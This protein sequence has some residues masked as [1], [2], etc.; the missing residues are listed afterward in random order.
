MSLFTLALKQF[1]RYQ[2]NNSNFSQ[3]FSEIIYYYTNNAKS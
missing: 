1:I 3:P 2:G